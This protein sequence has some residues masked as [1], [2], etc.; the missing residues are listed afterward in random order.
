M[1]KKL[2]KIRLIFDPSYEGH[3][4]YYLNLL[5]NEKDDNFYYLH[6]ELIKRIKIPAEKADH[7]LE[8]KPEQLGLG[9]VPT[10]NIR[11]SI[12]KRYHYNYKLW[13]SVKNV[14]KKH[15]ISHVVFIEIDSFVIFLLSV[16]F[17]GIYLS[18]IYYKPTDFRTPGAFKERIKKVIL[19]L[20]LK[21]KF[22]EKIFLLDEFFILAG[23]NKSNAKLHFLPDPAP[24]ISGEMDDTLKNLFGRPMFSM[25]FFGYIEERKG[26]L[27]ALDSLMLLPDGIKD[28]RL[29]LAGII[30]PELLEAIT[31]KTALMIGKIEMIILNRFI[32]ETELNTLFRHA[33][34][35][36][37][38][39]LNHVGSSGLINL[40]AAYG[41]PVITQQ[42]QL[43]GDLMARYGFGLTVNTSQPAEIARAILEI[44]NNGFFIDPVKSAT[45]LS[46]HREE[47][48]V[49]TL[50]T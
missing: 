35:L 12:F 48:F 4:S 25:L 13:K 7:V 45:Y 36:L 44:K 34:L 16:F 23:K 5:V 24:R 28:T 31:E 10:H 39:Y 17:P 33:D 11:S 49:C 2:S 22:I 40:A 43:I 9:F 42:S 26:I 21:K 46:A 18:G 37:A 15:G 8:I 27:P 20:L 50:L 3:H 1:E 6:P 38:P 32:T 30:D 29:I 19:F 41:K 14:C 47:N